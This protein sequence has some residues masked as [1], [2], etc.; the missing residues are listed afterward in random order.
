[1]KAYRFVSLQV[2]ALLVTTLVAG[3]AAAHTGEHVD[4]CKN[5]DTGPSGGD[6]PPGFVGGLIGGVA[7]FLGDLFSA[8]PV[9]NFVKGFFGAEVC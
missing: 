3:V 2:A 7:G 6:G 1:M 5:A 8:L 4:E 9:P